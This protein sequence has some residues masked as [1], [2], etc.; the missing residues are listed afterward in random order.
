MTTAE[1]ATEMVADS[2]FMHEPV[3]YADRDPEFST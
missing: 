2:V 1:S 3:V